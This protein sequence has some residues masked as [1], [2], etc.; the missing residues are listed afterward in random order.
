MTKPN[1]LYK[2]LVLRMFFSH[3]EKVSPVVKKSSM[4]T[5]KGIFPKHKVVISTLFNL[6]NFLQQNQIPYGKQVNQ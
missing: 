3:I 2:S 4:S 5:L 1:L 6:M